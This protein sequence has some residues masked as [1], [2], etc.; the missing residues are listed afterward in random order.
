MNGSSSASGSTPQVRVV[1]TA[2]P[3]AIPCEGTTSGTATAYRG[4]DLANDIMVTVTA[5]DG[6]SVSGYGTKTKSYTA[7]KKDCGT[8]IKFSGSGSGVVGVNTANVDVV[9]LT[10]DHEL[11]YLNGADAKNYYEVVKL[12]APLIAGR[13]GPFEWS[14]TKGGDKV[15]FDVG[16]G[17]YGQDYVTSTPEIKVHSTGASSAANDV[18]IE[19][20]WAQCVCT[21]DFVVYKPTASIV[22]GP[23]DYPSPSDLPIGYVSGW[24]FKIS[25]QF[26]RSIP[27]PIEVHEEFSDHQITWQGSDWPLATETHFTTYPDKPYRFTDGHRVNRL[28]LTP[29]PFPPNSG[30]ANTLVDNF[31]QIWRAGSEERGHGIEILRK[32]VIRNRSNA[33]HEQ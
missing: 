27:F 10:F 15:E 6:T 24:K 12:S 18:T 8:T 16:S 3:Y 2:S 9:K 33:R 30:G 26:G 23:T 22:T 25:D 28:T 11:W 7:T 1:L 29:R 19:L 31:L 20:T 5:P 32:R 14:I 4:P 21:I 17:V 13:A